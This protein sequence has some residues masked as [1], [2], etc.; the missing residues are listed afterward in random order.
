MMYGSAC[1]PSR[2]LTWARPMQLN[3]R[4]TVLLLYV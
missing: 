1:L 2:V 4:N 3:D